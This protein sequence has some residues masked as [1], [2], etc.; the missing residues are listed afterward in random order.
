MSL[1]ATHVAAKL[2][3]R[4]EAIPHR[5]P[6]PPSAI[7]APD[8]NGTLATRVHTHICQ[9]LEQ[10]FPSLDHATSNTMLSAVER[11]D[12][13]S[14]AGATALGLMNELDNASTVA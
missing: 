8:V 13:V 7:N 3:P 14:K 10:L 2:S 5:F 11:N 12:Q 6:P 4:W 1:P 9:T